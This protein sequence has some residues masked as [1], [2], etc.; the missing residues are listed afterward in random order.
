MKDNSPWYFLLDHLISREGLSRSQIARRSGVSA[1]TVT[2]WLRGDVQS[3]RDWQ[4]LAQVLLAL[5]AT[6]SETNLILQGAGHPPIFRLARR[7]SQAEMV[8]L[9]D[10]LYLDVPF[11]APDRSIETVIGRETE[12]VRAVENLQ[13]RQRCVLVGMAGIGKTTL[14]IELA[15][16]LRHEYEEGVFWGNLRTGVADA[17]LESWGQALG[18]DMRRMADF[19]SRAAAMRSLLAHKTVLIILD[20]VVDG[21]TALQMIPAHN[22]D[23]AVLVTTR[24][25]DAASLLTRRQSDL[26]LQLAP[27][28]RPHSLAILA[29]VMGQP[30]IDKAA[31]EADQLAALL[32]DMPLAL[33]ISAALCVDAGLTLQHLL[34]LLRDLNHRLDHLRLEDRPLVRLAFEQS[35]AL[36]DE[37]A[38]R[39][40]A[41]LAV[42]G[43][44][45]FGLTAFAASAGLTEPEAA[46]L[47]TRLCRR[48]LLTMMK[49]A[50]SFG[51]PQYQ[52]HTLLAAFAAEKLAGD[53]PS[54]ERFSAYY[55][56]LAAY[57]GW[58]RTA[59]QDLWSNVMAGME[60]AHRQQSWPRVLAYANHLTEAWR[61]QGLYGLAR[62]GFAWALDAACETADPAAEAQIRLAWGQACLEQS[63]FAES[64]ELLTAALVLFQ[65]VGEELGVANAHYHLSRVALQQTRF[66]DAESAVQQAYQGYQQVEDV[67]GMGRAL[68]RLG[69]I[70]Y[71]RGDNERAVGL[72]MDA[73]RSQ[74]QAGDKLGELRSRRLATLALILLT[75][76][77]EAAVQCRVAAQLVEEV[78][79]L[80]ETAAFYYTYADL[81]RQQQAFAE[82]HSYAQKALTYFRQMADGS[83]EA[84]ALLLL[85]GI[86]V[87]WN[88]AEPSRQQFAEGLSYCRNGL[89]VSE[90]VGYEVGKAFLLLMNGR[91]LAQQGEKT[92]ACTT[93]AEALRLAQ[94]L[95]HTWLQRRLQTLI[96]ET[97][98]TPR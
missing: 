68:Y 75:Q 31:V 98:C 14:A 19:D 4:P 17:V 9:A 23:C 48:S 49:T 41:T 12:L 7:A 84:N 45:P 8:L 54:W 33:H 37:A 58:W 65:T 39:G 78:D 72:V 32:G 56:D 53:D 29:A 59:E 18:V 82:S 25:E 1:K 60:T 89:A 88:E 24:S 42:F 79:D 44:R 62:Q 97:G 5:R 16:Q 43:G 2:S 95:Q 87:F 36:L 74:Q 96:D 64:Q 71:F 66:D 94:A 80:A 35:W 83:S 27:M 6:T 90:A 81:L 30:A 3:P 61:R 22:L 11:M 91:L 93:W 50:A 10:W 73:I 13:R 40:L 28:R 21:R 67:I 51:T 26:V 85:A 77:D 46:L 57:P 69:E 38:R 47:L 52:Q 20:D 15:H 55:A 76:I 92:F 63:D 86:E 70:A 34:V